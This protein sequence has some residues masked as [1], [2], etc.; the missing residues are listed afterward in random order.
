MT[1]RIKQLEDNSIL[2]GIMGMHLEDFAK[3]SEE[4]VLTT[5]LRLITDYRYMQYELAQ[6]DL[7]NSID[8]DNLNNK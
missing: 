6:K 2:L 7:Y 8:K 3:D 5:L 4:S 1:E